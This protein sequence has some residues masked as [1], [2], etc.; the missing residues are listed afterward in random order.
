[1]HPGRQPPLGQTG[2][3]GWTTCTEGHTHWGPRGAAGVLVAEHG[4]ALLQ[5]RA[6]WAHHGGTW[7]VPGGARERGESAVTAALREA[8]GELGLDPSAVT[9]QASYVAECGGWT[10]ET[11]LA[12]P[13]RTLA[14]RDMAESREHRWV[15]AGDVAALPLHPAFRTTWDDPASGLRD[16]VAGS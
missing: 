4:R 13:R 8:D 12:T 7:S 3:V 5:L 16:F 6:S 2:P 15:P 11:V 10:Y 9:P 1:M 14:L